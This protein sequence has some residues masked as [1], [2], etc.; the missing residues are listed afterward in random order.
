MQIQRGTPNIINNPM[1]NYYS[2]RYQFGGHS[3]HCGINPKTGRCHQNYNDNFCKFENGKCSKRNAASPSPKK[4]V[5]D[6]MSEFI[7]DVPT[8]VVL[9]SKISEKF[10][11]SDPMIK[12]NTRL[13]GRVIDETWVHVIV[14]NR[15]SG[16]IKLKHLRHIYDQVSESSS[17][18]DDSDKDHEDHEGHEDHEDHADHEIIP[19]PI[20]NPQIHN[21]IPH[22]YFP[23]VY[24]AGVPIINKYESL[25]TIATWNGKQLRGNKNIPLIKG[26]IYDM[27]YDLVGDRIRDFLDRIDTTKLEGFFGKRDLLTVLQ[28]TYKILNTPEFTK[29]NIMIY[30]GPEH[31]R[32]HPYWSLAYRQHF[33]GETN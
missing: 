27:Y 30:E 3:G 17:G 26:Y 33:V 29:D 6:D 28:E 19:K 14:P 4:V 32:N 22:P 20:D 13:F 2:Y 8:E 31:Y 25:E 16:Y 1:R 9:R 21:P 5:S 15:G 7:V 24:K 23:V 12:R 18:S 10:S 11:K